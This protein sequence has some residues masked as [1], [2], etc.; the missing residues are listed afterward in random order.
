VV[1]EVNSLKVI[2]KVANK[3]APGRTPSFIEVHIIKALEIINA[4]KTIGRKGLSK[5]LG[6]GEGVVRTL[7]KHLTIEGLIET[8]R[9]GITL[10]ES[11]K[12]AFL[13]L[14]SRISDGIEIPKSSLTV[15]PF[16]VAVLVRNVAHR[17][18]YGLEQRDA[19]IK[20]GALGATTLVFCHN[21]ITMPGVSEDI[22]KNIQPTYEILVTKLRPRENDVIIIGS[23]DEKRSAEFGAMAAAFELIKMEN[24]NDEVCI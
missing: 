17:V 13:D 12:K 19:A 11:G 5:S 14:K 22:F 21:K 6:L 18:K 2:E 10:S 3:I 15:R 24:C 1:S 4:E 20:V 23:A 16:D 7:L 9:S 8:S